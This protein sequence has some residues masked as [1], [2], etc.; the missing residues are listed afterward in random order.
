MLDKTEVLETCVLHR[1]FHILPQCIQQIT[2][3][4][5]NRCTQIQYRF[6]VISEAPSTLAGGSWSKNIVLSV[7][8]VLVHLI[9]Y[10]TRWVKTSWTYSICPSIYDSDT[11]TFMIHACRI[12]IS[13]SDPGGSISFLTAGSVSMKKIILWPEEKKRL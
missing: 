1:V 11:F 10:Y 12:V 8:E 6:A 9:S 7:Q 4:S 5:Q 2:Q 3:P 13:V